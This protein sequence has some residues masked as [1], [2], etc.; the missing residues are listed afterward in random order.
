M[1][2]HREEYLR[3]QSNPIITRGDKA[4]AINDFQTAIVFYSEALS[5]DR[6]NSDA[7]TKRGKSYLFTLQLEKAI[8]DF[9]ISNTINKNYENY[10]GIGEA[11]TLKKD[12]ENAAENFQLA[13]NQINLNT[14]T[15][16]LSELK[17]IYF[18]HLANSNYEL[19]KFD[20]AFSQV[21][22]AIKIEPSLSFCYRLRGI[23]HIVKKNNL[24][25][26]EDLK[27]AKALGDKEANFY[28]RE[29]EL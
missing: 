5:I 11:Y 27:K 24:K 23:L 3:M 15:K 19:Y 17:A 14:V 16:N 29:F 7:L 6:N 13:I 9:M 25:A 4:F 12:Y 1:A 20:D 18:Y 21:N 8:I 2:S 26:L 22:E 10:A 28:I